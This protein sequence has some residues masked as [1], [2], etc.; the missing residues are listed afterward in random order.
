MYLKVK[1]H[2]DPH[3]MTFLKGFYVAA[4][5]SGKRQTVWYPSPE[6]LTKIGVSESN[7]S[8]SIAYRKLQM[9]NPKV[10]DLALKLR[11]Y[12][13]VNSWKTF[14]GLPMLAE[15]QSMVKAPIA[16]TYEESRTRIADF[17]KYD[18]PEL[19]S[20]VTDQDWDPMLT[21]LGIKD[22]LD[23]FRQLTSKVDWTPGMFIS[24]PVMKILASRYS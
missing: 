2:S 14:N 7:P 11:A 4:R 23:N 9:A 18:R 16:T 22:D 20:K 24:H 1:V 15:F 21:T 17:K 10:K 8:N 5:V 19:S 13:I 6:I 12:D 3:C